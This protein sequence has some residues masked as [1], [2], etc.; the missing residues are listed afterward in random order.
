MVVPS[1]VKSTWEF[2]L[3]SLVG[4]VTSRAQVA[5]EWAAHVGC[6]RIVV[7]GQ[8]GSGIGLYGLFQITMLLLLMTAAAG[9]RPDLPVLRLCRS[10][11]SA[12]PSTLRPPRLNFVV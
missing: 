6:A 12:R 3:Q 7:F 1:V 2:S 5:V 9:M 4:Q 8:L 11:A 10:A